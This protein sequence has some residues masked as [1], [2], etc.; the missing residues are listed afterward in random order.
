MPLRH[1]W[2]EDRTEDRTSS[3]RRFSVLT[4][5]AALRAAGAAPAAPAG[6]A[7][8][9]RSRPDGQAA[10]RRGRRD[11][12]V[13]PTAPSSASGGGAP[14]PGWPWPGG[15]YRAV[16]AARELPSRPPSSQAEP[17]SLA[18][19]CPGRSSSGAL[20]LDTRG[21]ARSTGVWDDSRRDGSG[22]PRGSC[23]VGPTAPA[24]RRCNATSAQLRAATRQH[25]RSRPPPPAPEAEPGDMHRTQSP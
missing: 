22:D 11:E 17:S 5:R 16:A 10:P 1:P 3:C 2:S 19:G 25:R 8:F 18:P 21:Q 20:H 14:A 6:H 12:H 9:G 4:S 24:G 13:S 23:G 15:E 7:A